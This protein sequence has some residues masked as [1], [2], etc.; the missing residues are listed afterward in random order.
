MSDSE[1]SLIDIRLRSQSNYRDI[2][3]DRVS[4]IDY[5]HT[6]KDVRLLQYFC[7]VNDSYYGLVRV[8]GLTYALKRLFVKVNREKIRRTSANYMPVPDYIVGSLALPR[9][10]AH[11]FNEFE[12]Q[13]KN[14]K[15]IICCMPI[16]ADQMRQ[17]WLN[18]WTTELPCRLEETSVLWRLTQVLIDESYITSWDAYQR[19]NTDTDPQYKKTLLNRVSFMYFVFDAIQLTEL[20]YG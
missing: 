8:N 6:N 1:D 17:L 15:R 5:I 9:S 3:K 13:L 14:E 12:D 7:S 11:F 19:K 4:L 20:V 16:Y 10:F 2:S 18:W